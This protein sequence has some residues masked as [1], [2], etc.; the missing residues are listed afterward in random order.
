MTDRLLQC[1]YS[2]LA[3]A[4]TTNARDV[5]KFQTKLRSTKALAR[6]FPFITEHNSP[7]LGYNSPSASY[8]S[9]LIY[10][11]RM[12]KLNSQHGVSTVLVQT[13]SDVVSLK[14]K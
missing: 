12:I 6:E 1:L 14:R 9:G 13:N 10:V 2:A 8:V 7:L 4:A 3:P 11:D 5:W